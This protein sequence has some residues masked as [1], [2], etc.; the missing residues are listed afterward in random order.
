[1]NQIANQNRQVELRKGGCIGTVKLARCSRARPLE[2]FHLML[3]VH[4]SVSIKFQKAPRAEDQVLTP[5][6]TEAAPPP[7][8]R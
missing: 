6:T 2:P 4:N 7:Q 8:N 1:M 5:I 3:K